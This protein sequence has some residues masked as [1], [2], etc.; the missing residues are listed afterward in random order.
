MSLQTLEIGRH[1][2][3][4]P[5]CGKPA[6][7]DKTFGVTVD[8][9]GFVAQCFRC[10]H[11][12][13]A[14]EKGSS[15]GRLKY[16][17]PPKPAPRPL[18]DYWQEVWRRTQ[19]IT[20]E[21]IA[22]QYLAARRCVIPP[23]D[24]THLR[25][26]PSL[27]HPSGYQGPAL[28]ALVTDAVT[29]EPRT[30]HRTWVRADGQKADIKAWCNEHDIQPDCTAP[31]LLAGGQDKAGGVCRLWP[32]EAVTTGLGV[33]EGIESALSLAH[34]YAPVWSCIDAGNLKDFP[35]LAGVETLVIARDIDPSGTGQKAA[36]ELAMRWHQ[37]GREVFIT[38]QAV[39]DINDLLKQAQETE[40]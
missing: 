32:D 14:R 3:K 19:P 31:R 11:V 20:V 9:T 18:S 22:G 17:P 23:A 37:A 25:W 21:S 24:T 13:F 10:G 4:C 5:A 35:L 30:I 7:S 27:K 16:V 28:V 6:A 33:A 38:D 8:N 15:S 26:S 12:E 36:H 34:G 39:N 1:R 29:A 2:L 40:K